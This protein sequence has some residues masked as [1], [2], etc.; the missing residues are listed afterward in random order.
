LFG[1][2]RQ[3]DLEIGAMYKGQGKEARDSYAQ[4][5][6]DVLINSKKFLAVDYSVFL[7]ANDKFNVYPVIA[8]RSGMK[9]VNLFKRPVLNRTERDKAAYSET[10]FHLKAK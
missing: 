6:S 2:H 1:F 3:D 10:I 9:I 5:I 7:V 8:E 4:G